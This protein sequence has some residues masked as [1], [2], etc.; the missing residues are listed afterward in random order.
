MENARTLMDIIDGEIKDGIPEG[1]YLKMCSNLK[2]IFQALERGS[3]PQ[4]NPRPQSSTSSP[5]PLLQ[6]IL[7]VYFNVLLET[8]AMTR[9]PGY[10]YATETERLVRE[11]MGGRD[12]V[13]EV[14]A[15]G[16][17]HPSLRGLMKIVKEVRQKFWKPSLIKEAN[18][19]CYGYGLLTQ[20]AVSFMKTDDDTQSRITALL[21]DCFPSPPTDDE[22]S[23]LKNLFYGNYSWANSTASRFGTI[24]KAKAL[25]FSK[26]PLDDIF[27]ADVGKMTEYARKR[28]AKRTAKQQAEIVYHPIKITYKSHWDGEL[29]QKSITPYWRFDLSYKGTDYEIFKH[30]FAR[31]FHYMYMNSSLP[32]RCFLSWLWLLRWEGGFVSFKVKQVKGGVGIKAVRNEKRT[33]QITMESQETRYNLESSYISPAFIGFG[34]YLVRANFGIAETPETREWFP[35]ELNQQQTITIEYEGNDKCDET[36]AGVVNIRE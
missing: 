12:A 34:D 31:I 23:Q 24:L 15:P 25:T 3:P 6:R 8:D 9:T 14:I 18:A 36:N 2:D 30:D 33:Y 35:N 19:S 26:V 4:S 7:S 1:T 21:L 22:L 28:V 20:K 16:P 11:G 10:I 5:L 27:K 29:T 13:L 32:R 17:F